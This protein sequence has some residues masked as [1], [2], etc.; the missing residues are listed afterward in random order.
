MAEKNYKKLVDAKSQQGENQLCVD[1]RAK[2]PKWASVRYGT[3]FCLD[4]AAVHRSLGVYLDFVKSVTLDSWD[5]EAYLP[6]EYGGN[7]RFID[8]LV[9]NELNEADLQGK[10]LNS[11]V[12]EYSKELMHSIKKETGLELRASEKKST[13]NVR[14]TSQNNRVPIRE[15]PKK[16][17][18]YSS[19]NLSASLSSLTSSFTEKVKSFTEKTVEYGSKIGT[20]VKNQAMN[21]IEKGTESYANLNQ[22]TSTPKAQQEVVYTKKESTKKNKDWS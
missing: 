4:C 12:I 5:K 10:Y 14:S 6:I 15:E 22:P 9:N 2:N 7:Q 8:Y 17:P 18:I 11:K 13:S 20:T 3:F 16:Q 1:C 19:S 21:L